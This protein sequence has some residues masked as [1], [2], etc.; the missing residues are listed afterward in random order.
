MKQLQVRLGMERMRKPKYASEPGYLAQVKKMT[1]ALEE[2]LEY[3]FEQFEDV[4]PDIAYEAMKPTFDKSQV[5]VPRESG[6][7]ARSGYLEVI[8]RG[9]RP[10]VEI[11]YGK[12]GLPRYAPYVHEMTH[13]PHQHPTSAKFL[14]RA[15]NEDL[16][17][18]I[19]R[20]AEGY[21][22]FMRA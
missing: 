8:E 2:D 19:D 1:K 6:D 9:K 4:T 15:I 13:I 14:E 20:V 16:F 17:D 22:R 18:I 12:G 10:R 7:L 5:Y 21:R 11:G 3:I